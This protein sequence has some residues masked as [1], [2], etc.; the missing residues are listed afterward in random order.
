[1]DAHIIGLAILRLKPK[2]QFV[3]NGSNYS[4]IEWLDTEQTQP[5]LEE[6]ETEI[7]NPTPQPEPTIADKL[8]SVGLSVNELKAA[9]GL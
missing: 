9:L 1:M 7:A 6:L 8:A 5:T 2:A 4:D 3:V